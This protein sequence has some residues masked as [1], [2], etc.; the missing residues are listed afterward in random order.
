[1][2]NKEIGCQSVR[3]E[4]KG[5]RKRERE[6][7]EG[8]TNEDRL[9]RKCVFSA[10]LRVPGQVRKTKREVRKGQVGLMRA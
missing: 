10:R 2:E 7:E 6:R 9:R 4:K 3:C 1:M 5:E 8:K